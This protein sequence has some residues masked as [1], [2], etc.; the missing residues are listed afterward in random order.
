LNNALHTSI[1]ATDATLQ[2]GIVRA[3]LHFY[4]FFM[5]QVVSLGR[6]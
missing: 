4:P 6:E 2:E 1:E 3:C 5:L